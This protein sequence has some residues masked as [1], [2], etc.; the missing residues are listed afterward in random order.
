M[1]K[2]KSAIEK[3]TVNEATFTGSAKNEVAPS[4][5]NYFYGNNG[6]GKT[7]IARAIRSNTGLS[8]KT[9]K[10]PGDYNII[11]Y[12]QDFVKDELNIDLMPGILML[13][14]ENIDAQRQ[15]EEKQGQQEQLRLQLVDNTKSR[16][17]KSAE[18][19]NTQN[20]YQSVCW[21]AAKDVK[22]SFGGGKGDFRSMALCAERIS[23]TK[24]V[25]HDIEMLKKQY[26]TATD[27]NAKYYDH[28]ALLDLSKLDNIE[29][30]ELLR[31]S[32]VSASDSIFNRFMQEI[33][34]V[35]WVK[36]GYDKFSAVAGDKCPYCQEEL[37]RGF[38]ETLKACF[39]EQYTD[40]CS[41]LDKYQTKYVEYMNA[42]VDTV[43]DYIELLD[44]IP[45]SFCDLSELNRNL[46]ML[47]N[48]IQMNNNRI[49]GKVDT[50]SEPIELESVKTC[51]ENIN[52]LISETNERFD[53]NNVIFTSKAKIQDECLDKAWEWLAHDLRSVIKT[54]SDDISAI[55]NDLK[56]LQMQFQTTQN[57]LSTIKNEISVLTEKLGGSVSTL[58][59][60][61][62]LL[63]KYGFRGF[64][65]REHDKI[66]DKYIVVRQDGSTADNLSEGE[67]N[68][69]AFLYF[70]HLVQGSWKRED[71][72]KEKIVV[73]DDPVSS[74]DASVLFIVGS[75]VRRLIDDC[76]CDGKDHNIRQ[77]FILTHNPYFHKEVSFYRL[78]DEYYKKVSFYEVKK[79]ESNISSISICERAINSVDSDNEFENFSP[80]QN[81]Y[82][83]L[84]NEYKEVS[85]TATL[86]SIMNRIVEY[87]F[88]QLCSYRIEELRSRVL[89]HVGSENQRNLVNDILRYIYDGL[90]NKDDMDD[91]IY[92]VAQTDNDEYKAAFRAIFE[93][94]GQEPHYRKMTGEAEFAS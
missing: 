80:V 4:W 8:L 70:Y 24:P 75:L 71:L 86:L 38:E 2:Y 26:E 67:S 58:E 28:L 55:D 13:G 66:P 23:K 37:P 11:V 20:R 43:Q 63:V 50:P 51:L 59:K 10:A 41:K 17:A 53:K 21:E 78:G 9:G 31:K 82:T 49:R 52:A 60:V 33:K 88:V 32:I 46:K 36:Q 47:E 84:W 15:V 64:S 25:E 44:A 73:I 57:S 14:A 54:F 5:I 81:S 48:I 40:D 68:F 72:V 61:N 19:A 87:H 85:T 42:F 91:G 65:L 94:M 6:T 69:I 7:T 27:P 22:S 74:M 76:Y 77:I 56:A 35:D 45:E 62:S 16:E 89:S 92:F 18:H 12:N 90:N 79:S 34:A 1:S 30:Y 3:I 83:A 39:D 29:S 93:A